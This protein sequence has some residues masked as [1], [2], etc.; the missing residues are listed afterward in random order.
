MKLVGETNASLMGK[1]RRVKTSDFKKKDIHLKCGKCGDEYIESELTLKKYD[2]AK[3][4]CFPCREK[5]RT[6]DKKE[7]NETLIALAKRKAN[8]RK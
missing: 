5:K 4:M 7:L 1:S 2:N 8:P 3:F 6:D